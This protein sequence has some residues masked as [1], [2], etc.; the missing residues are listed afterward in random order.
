MQTKIL[1][2]I[3]ATAVV[4]IA[5]IGVTFALVSAQPQNSTIY[6]QT[7]TAPYNGNYGYMMP[8]I[9]NGTAIVP[10]PQTTTLYPQSAYPY[11]YGLGMGRVMCG[12]YW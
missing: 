4:A 2:A 5:L 7:P 8:Y 9:N 1:L 3:I 6:S 10:Y 11:G 12:R